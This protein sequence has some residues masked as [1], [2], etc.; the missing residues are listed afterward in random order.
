MDDARFLYPQLWCKDPWIMVA[1]RNVIYNCDII[2]LQTMKYECH[3]CM[4]VT[5]CCN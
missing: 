2:L 5:P 3:T 4:T 1:T